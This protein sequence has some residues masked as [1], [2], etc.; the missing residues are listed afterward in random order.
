ME[1]FLTMQGH[2]Y[3]RLDGSVKSEQRSSLISR[4]SEEDY[5]IFLLSTRAGGLGLNLQVADTVILYD[6]DWNPHV[7]LQAQDRAHRIGQKNEVRILRLVTSD[8]IEEYILKKANIKLS[9]DEK[10]IQAGRFDQSSTS[11]EREL[12]MKELLKSNEEC[13]NDD[14]YDNQELNDI[15]ARD[16]REKDVFYSID[17]DYAGDPLMT[18]PGV[19]MDCAELGCSDE[20]DNEMRKRRKVNPEGGADVKF[21]TEGEKIHFIFN[22]MKEF[23]GKE[24]KRIEPFLELPSRREHPEYYRVVKEPTSMRCIEKKLDAYASVGEMKDDLLLMFDNALSYSAENSVERDDA[25]FLR[26]M[27]EDLCGD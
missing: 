16:D 5:F 24:G 26:K 14:V 10:V 2:R 6:S 22:R 7:D 27:A 4:F 8:S 3:L 23:E 19:G 20:V 9:I 15:L 17:R 25:V 11:E 12:F 1:D 18:K 13:T 21:N